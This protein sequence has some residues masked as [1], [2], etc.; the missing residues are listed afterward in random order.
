MYILH[1]CRCPIR[2]CAEV[3]YVIQMG[4]AKGGET[5][6]A[7]PFVPHS[8]QPKC[9]DTLTRRPTL[10]ALP[11]SVCSPALLTILVVFS[12]FHQ[13]FLPRTIHIYSTSAAPWSSVG[14]KHKFAIRI[15]C[16]HFQAISC[17]SLRK[18]HHAISD[19][20]RWQLTTTQK[21]GV[22]W[23]KVATLLLGA[24]IVYDAGFQIPFTLRL[25][26]GSGF[27]FCR[28]RTKNRWPETF[29][30]GN[31]WRSSH[32]STSQEGRDQILPFL[33]AVQW[34]ASNMMS[35]DIIVFRYSVSTHPDPDTMLTCAGI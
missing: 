5:L 10:V 32:R 16:W 22:N 29:T 13:D 20:H 3:S 28:T 12:V 34:V 7:P 25:D 21:S 11:T 19:W 1:T 8:G 15:S 14:H 18:H 9:V 24:I 33:G 6:Q 23:G 17:W 4:E 31:S 26:R 30:V 2:E 35:A 27:A